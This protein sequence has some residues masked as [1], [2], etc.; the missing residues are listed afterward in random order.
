M[1]AIIKP[2][3]LGAAP[4][5]W[6][7]LSIC[8]GLTEDLLPVVSNPNA[9]ISAGSKMKATGKT[10]SMYN[11]QRHVAGISKWTDKVAT[12]RD[13]ARWRNEP[14]Y[15]ICIQ[16]RRLR[17]LDVDVTDAR[18]SA[19][20][21]EFIASYYPHLPCRGRAGSSKFL[22]AFYIDGGEYV[23]RKVKVQGEGDNILEFLATGQQFI[24]I[25]THPTGQRYE[26][27]GGL[28]GD[29]PTLTAVEFED[30]WSALVL[31]FGLED[32]VTVGP[33]QTIRETRRPSDKPDE[34]ADYLLAND[35]VKSEA[36][37]G[38]LNIVCPF[39][40][41]HTSDTSESST[42]YFPAGVGGFEQGH[43][44]C[45]HAHCA[46]RTD[47]DFIDAVG[48]VAAQFDVIVPEA[49]EV[50]RKPALERDTN[51][52]VKAT[53]NNVVTGLSA[54]HFTGWRIALDVFRD[55]I[56]R[57]PHG[58]DDWRPFRDDDYVRL[59]CVLESPSCG[60]KPVGRELI[61][62]AVLMVAT[63]HQ[64]DSAQLWLNGLQWDGVPRVERFL[65]T[66]F[67]AEDSPYVRAVARYM[68]TALAGRVLVPGCKTDMVPIWVGKQGTRKSSGTA[69][70]VPSSTFFTE[71]N[72]QEDDEKLARK[73][74]GRLV[75]EIGELRGLHTKDLESIKAFITRTHETWVPKYKE[76]AIDF[77]RR[78]VFFGSTNQDEF[79][80]DET[81]NRRWL[82]VTTGEVDVDA[83][84]RDRA[85]LWAEARMLFESGGIQF[86]EA[87]TLANG[88][89]DAHM[90]HD[91][92][93]DSISA[94]LEEPDIAGV[95]PVMRGGVRVVDVLRG[96]L[97]FDDRQ[98]GRRDE[99]RAGKILRMLG[100]SR[101]QTRVGDV[102]Q[103]VYEK[104]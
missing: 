47:G 97:R 89:H 1:A 35:W 84:D 3:A 17:A 98:I 87:Q 18:V 34:L 91:A 48:Y 12:D 63:D 71:I 55:E 58:T 51:G 61:R 28:P 49:G 80:A 11:G 67:G 38:R 7:I 86:A 44:K 9:V 82:P 14:D 31:G 101:V 24:A 96:A 72:L 79:L 42:Q 83:I 40:S 73:M 45:L 21:R 46:G 25:G 26:W 32:P 85:V 29:F 33:R 27:D 74:R 8:C 52:W 53:V 94:W 90:I 22:L 2:A 68:W 15:G 13:V 43:F 10:P 62:D 69:A 81:G 37:D 88:V 30:L 70:L 23:K 57:A 99:M 41:E 92:W 78:M 59:R 76:F 103:W 75:G 64:F 39:E 65:S 56:M 104:S 93:L 20:I 102:R 77:P 66:H 5:D 16:T 100:Y 95:T 54:T 50:A 4:E 19:S 6:D 36:R 60:Y